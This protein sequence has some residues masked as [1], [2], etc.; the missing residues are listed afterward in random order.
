VRENAGAPDQGGHHWRQQESGQCDELSHMVAL[1]DH[2][3]RLEPIWDDNT[4]EDSK[5]GAPRPVFH[6]LTRALRKY[7]PRYD[8]DL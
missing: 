4:G 3:A 2:Q 5:L 1:A 8:C 6:G 7:V